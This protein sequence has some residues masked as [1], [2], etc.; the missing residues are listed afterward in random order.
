MDME[1]M[2]G[3]MVESTQ[4]IG[5]KESSMDQAWKFKQMVKRNMESGR[6]ARNSSG[7]QIKKWKKSVRKESWILKK[8]RR[9][10][11]QMMFDVIIIVI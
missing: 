3:V 9:N 5:N 7:C 1:H 8:N 11:L 4:G 6:K 2:S 10:T